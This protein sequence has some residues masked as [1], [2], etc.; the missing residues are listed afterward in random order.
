M[1][2]K[3]LPNLSTMAPRLVVVHGFDCTPLFK[4][5]TKLRGLGLTHCVGTIMVRG[6][7]IINLAALGRKS[8]IL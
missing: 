8:R 3:W 2:Q 7:S 6:L 1:F 5:L 4:E